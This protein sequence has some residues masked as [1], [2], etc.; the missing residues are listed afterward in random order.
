MVASEQVVAGQPEEGEEAS[1]TVHE[2]LLKRMEK[3][4]DFPAFS[5]TIMRIQS[6]S[7]SDHESQATLTNEILKDVALTNKLLRLVNTVHYARGGSI[8]TV[9]RATSLVGFNGVRNLALSLVLLEFMQ[10]RAHA[11]RLK[12]EFL[13]VLMAASI[14]RE[15][16]PTEAEGEE[17]FIGAMFQHL[18]RLLAEYYFPEEALKVR[19]LCQE[20]ERMSEDAAALETLGMSYEQ[21][22]LGMAREWN[23][24]QVIQSCIRKPLGKPPG[25]KPAADAERIRWIASAANQM[26]DILLLDEVEDR[27]GQQTQASTAYARCL[28]MPSRDIDKAVVKA[29]E[30][31][32]EMAAAMD[33]QIAPG[34]IAGRIL[35]AP[36]HAAAP[37]PGPDDGIKE[38]RAEQTEPDTGLSAEQR[39]I[40]LLMAGIQDVTNAMVEENKLGDILRMILETI[41]RGMGFDSVIFCMRDVKAGQLTGRFGLGQGADGAV[42]G[43]RVPCKASNADVFS[44][45][46][47]K[48]ADTLISDTRDPRIAE[49][50][51]AWYAAATSRPASFLLLPLMHKGAP[52]GLIY[53]DKREGSGMKLSDKQLGLLRT[54]RNQALMAI[55]QSS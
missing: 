52:I 46:C 6:I 55:R 33:I 23:L 44:M 39:T 54:L 3:K 42:K 1:V 13:R 28:G 24:P 25:T 9:S 27:A 15:L 5:G 22:G 36:E 31:L 18:G 7:S 49:R 29:R 17:V 19:R 43:F 35:M 16:A 11:E 21:L 12:Q 14:A 53:A 40:N 48:G 10:D 30:R 32:A 8:R 47:A 34:S 4:G 38:L 50:L 26:A 41:L 2:S 51:P 20:N 45:I 37:E